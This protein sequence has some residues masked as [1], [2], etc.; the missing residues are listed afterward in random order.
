MGA[1]EAPKRPPCSWVASLVLSA[2]LPACN[3]AVHP[4]SGSIIG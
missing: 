4:F 2:A 3:P 1:V